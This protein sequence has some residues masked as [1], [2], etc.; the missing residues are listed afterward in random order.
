MQDNKVYHQV[1]DKWPTVCFFYGF[2]WQEEIVYFY[3]DLEFHGPKGDKLNE[4]ATSGWFIE[5]YR[6]HLWW[7]WC[8][9]ST[10]HCTILFG[11]PQVPLVPSCTTFSHLTRC[12]KPVKL[13]NS[14]VL[15]TTG[16]IFF[17]F[18]GSSFLTFDKTSYSKFKI[19]GHYLEIPQMFEAKLFDDLKPIPSSG[20]GC[21]Y[22][23]WKVMGCLIC[24]YL[25]HYDVMMSV[26]VVWADCLHQMKGDN[27]MSCRDQRSCSL[28]FIIMSV[29]S[30]LN[31][32][33][34]FNGE[35][36]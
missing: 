19:C 31:M 28:Y 12:L 22:E 4:P 7:H 6:M 11:L 25:Y 2:S 26:D 33:R 21:W 9:V 36:E 27:D 3:P 17:H 29:G 24:T 30:Q 8:S 14:T 18:E 35:L 20:P 16:T 23:D 1:N 13:L 10:V 32:S 5:R 34:V 15:F